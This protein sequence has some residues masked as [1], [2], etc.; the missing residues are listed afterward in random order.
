MLADWISPQPEPISMQILQKTIP[1]CQET[2]HKDGW[3]SIM[4]R[5]E[6]KI[7]SMSRVPQSQAG[8]G[9]ALR[10]SILRGQNRS[11]VALTQNN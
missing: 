11:T 10:K 5:A 2:L 9:I 8:F 6:H 7:P 3:H 1:A 4:T